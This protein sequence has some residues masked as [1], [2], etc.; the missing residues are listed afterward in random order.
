MSFCKNKFW[1]ENPSDLFCSSQLVPLLNMELSEQMNSLTRLVFIIFFLILTL[2]TKISIIFI[3]LSLLFIIILYY[4]KKRSMNKVE[5]FKYLSPHNKKYTQDEKPYTERKYECKRFAIPS[6]VN[7]SFIKKLVGE[8]NPKTLNKP[9]IA[10]HPMSLDH[11]ADNKSI[12]HSHINK[13]SRSDLYL[14]GYELSNFYDSNIND[15]HS[16][17][18]EYSTHGDNEYEYI[19]NYHESDVYIKPHIHDIIE[20]I[21]A[22]QNLSMYNSEQINNQQFKPT[23]YKKSNYKN[24]SYNGQTPTHED[25]YDPRLYGYGSCNRVYIHKVTGQPRFYYDD[26]D[27]VR[28]P[29]YLSRSN[30]DFAKNTHSNGNDVYN[31]RVLAQNS[32][33]ENSLQYRNELQNKLMDKKNK[34]LILRRKYP[35]HNRYNCGI[36]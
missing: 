28:M 18:E 10:P 33:L 20:P 26:V 17:C 9:I 23:N 34:E 15:T 22:D 7:K 12:N 16:N 4:I 8:P 31:N 25:I 24:L 5:N 2:N 35:R 13:E 32:F 6:P 3:F 21:N 30:I 11:W 19:K 27:N 29:N 36:R 1:L 14:S